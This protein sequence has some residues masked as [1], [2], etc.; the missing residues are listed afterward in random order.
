MTQQIIKPQSKQEMFLASNADIAIYGGAAGG[1][2]TWA[3]LV[4]ALRYTMTKIG[5]NATIFRRQSKQITS[6]G[7]LWDA[8]S[9]MYEGIGCRP[10]IGDRE[11]VTPIG[12]RISFR[13][14]GHESD[15]LSY[16]GA[17]IPLIIFD[18]LTHFSKSVFLYMLSRN[19]STCGVR[20]YVRATTNPDNVSFVRDLISWWI[21]SDGYPII[22]RDGVIMWLIVD[23]DE[24]YFYE[25]KQL[26]IDNHPDTLPKSLTFISSKL[27]DNQVLCKA[28]PSYLA[29][30]MALPE[31]DRKQLLEGNWDVNPNVSLIKNEWWSEYT[32]SDIRSKK[33]M[34]VVHSWDTAFKANTSNDPTACTI[35]GVAKE[36]YYLLD[37]INRRMEYPELK[38]LVIAEAIRDNPDYLLIED[39]ASGQSLIQEL[40]KN[41]NFKVFGINPERDKLHRLSAVLTEIEA[42]NVYLPKNASWLKEFKHQCETFPQGDHDDIVDSMSQ[43]LNFAKERKLNIQQEINITIPK[44]NTHW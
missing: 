34:Y 13:H 16:Q 3:I 2:K 36:G 15:K 12:N 42:G 6:Q 21:G 7:G 24:F 40:Q 8:S 28:D 1:G 9:L 10:R 22:E 26:A 37:V 5:F 14:I 4:E 31:F 27:S 30:L 18:E 19:R 32:E 41:Y 23:N 38:Q 33:F 35:W 17:E 20:P 39:K 43:F 11:Y 25:S 29:N 44:L